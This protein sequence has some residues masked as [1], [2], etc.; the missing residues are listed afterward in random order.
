MKPMESKEQ[1]ARKIGNALVW[2]HV[3]VASTFA[4]LFLTG[5]LPI[6]AAPSS[7]SSHAISA[8]GARPALLPDGAVPYGAPNNVSYTSS[9]DGFPLSFWE[10]LPSGYSGASASLVVYLP[11]L[12]TSTANVTYG[13]GASTVPTQLINNASTFGFILIS[14]NTRSSAGYYLNTP[15]GGY[16]RQDVL[17]AIVVE[18]GRRTV[19]SVYFAGFSGGTAG[20]LSIVG[21][22]Q[23][24]NVKGIVTS[25]TITDM[26]STLYYDVNNNSDMGHYNAFVRDECGQAPQW[27]IPSGQGGQTPNRA[28]AQ[29]FTLGTFRYYPSNFSGVKLYLA[30]GGKDTEAENNLTTFPLFANLNSTLLGQ[31]GK[32]GCAG[33]YGYGTASFGQPIYN[34][35]TSTQ[36]DCGVSYINLTSPSSLVFQYDAQGTHAAIQPNYADVFEYW[37]G[38]LLGGVYSSTF[39]QTG[40]LTPHYYSWEHFPTL[41]QQTTACASIATQA[42]TA[43][44]TPSGEAIYVFISQLTSTRWVTSVTDTAADTFH[45]VKNVSVTGVEKLNLWVTNSTSGSSAN[46]VTVVNNV[47]ASDCVFV[48][49]VAGQRT[50]ASYGFLGATSTATNTTLYDAYTSAPRDLVLTYGSS[51]TNNIYSAVYPSTHVVAQKNV[52]T[53]FSEVATVTNTTFTV[54]S[55]PTVTLGTSSNWLALSVAIQRQPAPAAPT[56]LTQ[57]AV[58]TSSFNLS[59]SAPAGG[60]LLNYSFLIG[61][62][63]TVGGFSGLNCG[64]TWVVSAAGTA[65][66]YAF[67]TSV[68][69]YFVIPSGAKVCVR[70]VAWNA[71][72]QGTI[73]AYLNFTMN[74]TQQGGGG[75]GG[76]GGAISGGG[77]VLINP[78]LIIFGLLIVGIVAAAFVEDK[79]TRSRPDYVWR[80]GD[81]GHD[82]PISEGRYP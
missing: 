67:T 55:L 7:P 10:Y 79:K 62:N 56:A 31:Y 35:T 5:L 78:L 36:W 22:H 37:E 81:G 44:N 65:T 74:G 32:G 17:D 20:A 48:G 40:A 80:Y 69:G 51:P 12:G 57:S 49:G 29:L 6:S 63:G 30:A 77:S 26:A 53:T 71:T 25:A 76:G 38:Y 2:R 54:S 33:F 72:G 58:T 52:S 73:S 1:R 4:L 42:Q 28:A 13:V 16:Q 19:G 21:N 23:V 43:I 70:V 64:V 45:M 61:T 39:P 41:S 24:A 11:G 75:G 18:E 66:H 68:G 14:L 3:A 50:S 60:G 27:L 46:V 15:C 9:V 82:A 34:F 47:A 8:L 59:F